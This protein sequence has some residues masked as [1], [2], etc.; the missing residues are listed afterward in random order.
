MKQIPSRVKDLTDEVFG[1]LTV[2]EFA[3]IK[4]SSGRTS[5]TWLCRCDCGNE[6]VFPRNSLASGYANSCGCLRET[7]G[8]SDSPEYKSWEAMIQRC[9]NSNLKEFPNYGGRGIEVCP[10]WEDFQNFLDDMGKRPSLGHS[11]DRIDSNGN[12]EPNNCRWADLPQQN[13]NKRN[14]IYF[15]FQGQRLPLSEWSKRT[16]VSQRILRGRYYRGWP[17]EK[18][19]TTP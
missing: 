2:I 19:L 9:T 11:I 16:G 18:I 14:T 5:A 7:H 3:G 15:E 12:Y 13:N 17:V 1:K 6:K 10:R 8:I 4:K